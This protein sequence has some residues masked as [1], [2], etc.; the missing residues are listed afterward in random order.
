[1]ETVVK[2][3]PATGVA[4]VSIDIIAID[5]TLAPDAYAADVRPVKLFAESSFPAPINVEPECPI[6]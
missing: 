5:P 2:P 4:P 6:S 3:P 1:M